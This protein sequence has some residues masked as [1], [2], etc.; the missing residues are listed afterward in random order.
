M[1]LVP[2]AVQLLTP[3]GF[4]LTLH[5]TALE[6]AF[7]IIAEIPAAPVFDDA[8]VKYCVPQELAALGSVKDVDVALLTPSN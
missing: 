7:R 8:T 1:F 2:V 5:D 3:A 4:I 6:E